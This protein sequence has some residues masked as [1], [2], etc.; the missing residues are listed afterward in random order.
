LLLLLLGLA[1]SFGGSSGGL[2]TLDGGNGTIEVG[3][4]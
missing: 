2:V 1:G 3:Q 4:T